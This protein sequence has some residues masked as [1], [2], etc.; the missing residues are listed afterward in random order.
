MTFDEATWDDGVR[1]AIGC[2]VESFENFFLVCFKKFANGKRLAF[3]L[4]ERSQLD[5][6]SH[7]KNYRNRMHRDI[8]RCDL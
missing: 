6:A 7:Q 3:E 5:K 8:Q 2:D 4:S 1:S